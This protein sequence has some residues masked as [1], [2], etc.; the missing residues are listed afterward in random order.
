MDVREYV[1]WL[2]RAGIALMRRRASEMAMMPGSE[3]QVALIH[4]RIKKLEQGS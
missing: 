3:H 4:H 1:V 2:Q